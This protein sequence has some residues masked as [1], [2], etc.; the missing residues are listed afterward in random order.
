MKDAFGGILNIMFIA[1][2]LVIVSGILGFIVCYT[3]AFRMKNFVI[4]AI[5]QYET[6]GCFESNSGYGASSCSEKIKENA[7]SIGYSPVNVNCP[8]NF[9][10]NADNGDTFFCYKENTSN[11]GKYYSIVTQVDLDIPIINHIMGLTFFQVHGD[12]RVINT[13]F[14]E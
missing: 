13:R 3:K 10:P 8:K 4:S 12:T 9:S 5:E 6:Y 7:K 1:V 2:F 14:G 11:S